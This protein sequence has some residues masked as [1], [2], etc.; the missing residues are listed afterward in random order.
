[1]KTFE[2][3]ITECSKTVEELLPWNL[4]AL[5]ESEKSLILLDV[6]E[7]NEFEGC[8]IKGALNVPRGILEAACE[9]NYEDTVPELAAARDREIVI[10]CRSGKRS[11]LSAYIM[12]LMGFRSVKSL[13]LG[14]KG[15]S[16]Y[17]LPVENSQGQILETEQADAILYAPLRPEQ[18]KPK[19]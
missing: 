16:D 12:Q 2:D 5:L 18:I 11:V 19:S 3:F 9:Y 6:R 14:M 8:H 15:W 4:Q 10:I 17:E 1:M 13:K 7:P